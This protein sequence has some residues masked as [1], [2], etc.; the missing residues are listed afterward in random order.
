VAADTFWATVA[1]PFLIAGRAIAHAVQFTI[2]V[3][4]KLL[5]YTSFWLYQLGKAVLLELWEALAHLS[6]WRDYLKASL[7]VLIA[8]GFILTSDGVAIRALQYLS[9]PTPI[10]LLAAQD[11]AVLALITLAYALATLLVFW[12]WLAQLTYSLALARFYFGAAFVLIAFGLAGLLSFGTDRF[13]PAHV[14]GFSSL[15][16]YSWFMLIILSGAMITRSTAN[17][18]KPVS[19]RHRL[20]RSLPGSLWMRAHA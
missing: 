11:L 20:L 3:A 5:A 13:S 14:Q 8:I 19:P 1:A 2:N 17:W 16:I 7:T 15:G 18:R 12:L 4:W 10:S 9:L 6:F